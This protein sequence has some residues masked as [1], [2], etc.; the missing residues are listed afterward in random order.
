MDERAENE[1]ASSKRS[2]TAQSAFRSKLENR[3]KKCKITGSDTYEACHIVPYIYF[4]Y[5]PAS[6]CTLFQKSCLV[7][8]DK[9]DDV[10]NGLL[11]NKKWHTHF[12][13]FRITIILSKERYHVKACTWFPFPKED[14]AH[15]E[16][17]LVFGGPKTRR[18]GKVFLNF[19]NKEF[20][21]RE[22]I[23]AEKLMKAKAEDCTLPSQ[24]SNDTIAL[25]FGSDDY[26]IIDWADKV[27]R[28]GAST[29]L[30][31][32]IPDMGY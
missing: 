24:D 2:Q 4:S 17:Q 18:P 22:R 6:W 27:D 16:K 8:A 20:D 19:H 1:T 11:L 32:K 13:A 14:E 26:R 3:D 12:D 7:A 28:T 23:Q 30:D 21:E 25:K 29:Y 15:L 9:I 31:V 10:R 5:Y